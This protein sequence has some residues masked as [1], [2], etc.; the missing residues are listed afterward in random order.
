MVIES[1]IVITMTKILNMKEMQHGMMYIC[2][3]L[4][5]TILKNFN[6]NCYG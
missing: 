4:M 1:N 5:Q 3:F 6:F 2:N